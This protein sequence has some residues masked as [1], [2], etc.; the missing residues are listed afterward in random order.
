MWPSAGWSWGRR[1]AVGTY[2]LTWTLNH[3]GTCRICFTCQSCFAFGKSESFGLW[4]ENP[5]HISDMWLNSKPS[6]RESSVISQGHQ[7]TVAQN[8]TCIH[9]QD[10]KHVSHIKDI[11]FVC[12]VTH[13]HSQSV[14][15]HHE[16]H[17]VIAHRVFNCNTDAALSYNIHN[18]HIMHH[19]QYLLINEA[20]L[21][22]TSQKIF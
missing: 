19:R 13:L 12:K 8:V 14:H 15:I 5:V 20:T 16:Q 1:L 22:N 21:A 3:V 18:N 9:S 2:S 10:T 7:L 11:P 17:N 6:G 4:E